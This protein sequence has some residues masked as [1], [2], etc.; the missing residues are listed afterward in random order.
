MDTLF[1]TDPVPATTLESSSMTVNERVP[2]QVY[3]NAS[4]ASLAVARQISDLIRARAEDGKLC[5]LGLATGSSPVGVYN[6]LVRMHREENLSFANVVT[7]NLDE[8]Y[9]THHPG[10]YH[11]YR[12]SE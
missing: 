3:R 9:T 2:C 4:D 5:V 6:E 7:F 8:F 12:R 10:S 1:G 11:A